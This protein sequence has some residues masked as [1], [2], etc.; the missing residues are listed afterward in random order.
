[1]INLNDI[2]MS[3]RIFRST[4]IRLCIQK[5]STKRLA[6]GM[7]VSSRSQNI[8]DSGQ[9]VGRAG[10]VAEG[11]GGGDAFSASNSLLHLYRSNNCTTFSC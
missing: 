7:L 3:K 2:S 9:V 10:V 4:D 11:F 5:A 1:M 6:L 8:F